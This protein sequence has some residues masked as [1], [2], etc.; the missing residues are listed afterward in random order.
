MRTAIAFLSLLVLAGCATSSGV[1][2]NHSAPKVVYKTAYVIAH[3]GS[4]SDMD[5][6][7]QK[8]LLRHGL[9][10]TSGADSTGPEGAQL[11]VKY[12]DDWRWDLKMYLRSLDV[13]AFDAKTHVLLATASWKNSA[14]HGFYDE[15][16]AVTKLVDDTLEGIGVDRH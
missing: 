12:A 11:M 7:V 13:M 9:D 1:I 14:V 4:G 2:V 15:E 3:G 10:V 6:L 5:A 16:K 8:E